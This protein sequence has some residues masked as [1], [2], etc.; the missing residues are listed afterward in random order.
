MSTRGG[1]VLGNDAIGGG[2]QVI[3]CE[4][5][6]REVLHYN[7]TLSSMTAGQGSYLVEFSHY[8][9]MPPNIQQQ[10]MSHSKMEEEVLECK[11]PARAAELSSADS[12]N[13][14]QLSSAA[15]RQRHRTDRLSCSKVKQLSSAAP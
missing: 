9:I 2:F 7:R 13:V 10:I 6:M 8:E 11:P 1:R 14:E 12:P 3:H 15:H 5:P 4:I